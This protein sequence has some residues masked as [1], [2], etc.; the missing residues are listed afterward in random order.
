MKSG[1]LARVLATA[2]D[3]Y[4]TQNLSSCANPDKVYNLKSKTIYKITWEEIVQTMGISKHHTLARGLEVV[5]AFYLKCSLALA[6][7]SRSFCVCYE[8][9]TRAKKLSLLQ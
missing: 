2:K 5:L 8:T 7:I 9:F 6:T 1:R 3:G 4:E